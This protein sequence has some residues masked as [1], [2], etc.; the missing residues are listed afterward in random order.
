ML[1]SLVGH[2][3]R[4]HFNFSLITQTLPD[5]GQVFS[6]LA[7]LLIDVRLI[8]DL[9]K[10]VEVVSTFF[11]DGVELLRLLQGEAWTGECLGNFSDKFLNQVGMPLQP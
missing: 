1:G 11:N 2:D 8:H 5:A 6:S 3:H 4:S 7:I 9:Q 10:L